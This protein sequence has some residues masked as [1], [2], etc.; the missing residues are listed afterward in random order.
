MQL[1]CY[2]FDVSIQTIFLF[3][4]LKNTDPIILIQNLFENVLYSK[5]KYKIVL[6]YLSGMLKSTVNL[7]FQ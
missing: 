7:F 3:I 6:M 4:L 5:L 2:T 1:C